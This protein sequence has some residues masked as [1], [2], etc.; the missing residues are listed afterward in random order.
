MEVRTA[1]AA[2]MLPASR[3]GVAAAFR[4]LRHQDV[5]AASAPAFLEVLWSVCRPGEPL[6]ASRLAEILTATDTALESGR[7]RNILPI[8]S[9]DP[10]Y[11]PL[12]ACIADPPPVLWARGPL[13][14]LE[15]PAVAVV[16]SRAATPYALEVAM[17][18]AAELAARG[19]VVVSGLA[20]GVDSAA[21]RGTLAAGRT[22][23]VLGCGLD[24]VYPSEHDEL[25]SR[26]IEKGGVLLSELGPG[27]APLPEH[28]PLRNRI[29]SGLSL[30]TVVVE[31]S[32]HSG[33]LITARCAMEQGRDVMAVPG[34]VLSGRNRGS[35]ALLKDGAAVVETADDILQELGWPEARRAAT[36]TAKSLN[37]EPLIEQMLRGE[38]YGLDALVALTGMPAPRLLAR[39]TELELAGVIAVSGGQYLRRA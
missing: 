14:A 19:V 11:P 27:A 20:R 8:P 24:R 30:G 32:E 4:D 13:D 9:C 5:G 36:T 25:A 38:T 3:S 35:H 15:C 21:H 7:R 10:R 29:I 12:L 39:L 28:F 23:A 33:S 18:I 16:G 17:R 34:S 37:P 6:G 2:S 31:A 22:A 26:I 1:V